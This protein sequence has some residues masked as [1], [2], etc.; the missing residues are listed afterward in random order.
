ME[1]KKK[2]FGIGWFVPAEETFDETGRQIC[3]LVSSISNAVCCKYSEFERIEDSIT[4]KKE[5]CFVVDSDTYKK[6][7]DIRKEDMPA[8]IL[9]VNSSATIKEIMAL[10][11]HLQ[12]MVNNYF[13]QN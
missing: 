11:E 5:N 13:E 8:N 6:L 4:Y 1:L 2:F 9:Y 7:K 12:E 3:K 10:R